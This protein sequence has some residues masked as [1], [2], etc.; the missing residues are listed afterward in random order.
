[1]ITA[2]SVQAAPV[3]CL[4]VQRKGMPSITYWNRPVIVT[5]RGEMTLHG[6]LE[7][8]WKGM[9][10]W[11]IVEIDDELT[12]SAESLQREQAVPIPVIRVRPA[13]L[14]RG[15]FI[16]HL[17]SRVLRLLVPAAA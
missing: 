9:T 12:P 15:D 1:M 6:L 3:P 16:D 4:H 7:A 13:T 10:L 14:R 11:A 5:P 2:I 17:S 8:H